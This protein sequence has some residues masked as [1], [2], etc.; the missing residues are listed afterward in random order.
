MCLRVAVVPKVVCKSWR[1][2]KK[3]VL[4]FFFIKNLKIHSTNRKNF[5]FLKKNSYKKCHKIRKISWRV[6]TVN[7]QVEAERVRRRELKRQKES[8]AFLRLRDSSDSRHRSTFDQDRRHYEL[9]QVYNVVLYTTVG[10][11]GEVRGGFVFNLWMGFS[12]PW[13]LNF[14]IEQWTEFW[15]L[16]WI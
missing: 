9:F 11:G 5:Y 12:A 14:F 3:C 7:I 2:A 1:V 6:C 15:V 16:F 13:S 4:H 8:G 10:R